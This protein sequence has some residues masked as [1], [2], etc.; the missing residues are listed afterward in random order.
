MNFKHY[1]GLT[2][3]ASV[4]LIV[5]WGIHD[6]EPTFGHVALGIVA[7]AADFLITLFLVLKIALWVIPGL[8][9]VYG[10]MRALDQRKYGW[11]F[12][13]ANKYGNYAQPFDLQTGSTRRIESGN[14]QELPENYHNAP[15]ITGRTVEALPAPEEI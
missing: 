1:V 15:H 12:L 14:Y 7:A 11:R 9:L 8:L 4:C 6:S 10:L 2:L 5:A 13:R 3:L